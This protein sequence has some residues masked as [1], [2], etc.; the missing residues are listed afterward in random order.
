MRHGIGMDESDLPDS[1]ADQAGDRRLDV[2]AERIAMLFGQRRRKRALQEFAANVGDTLGDLV[3]LHRRVEKRLG[4]SGLFDY[5][6]AT[7]RG[8][9]RIAATKFGIGRGEASQAEFP[10]V[11]LKSTADLRRVGTELHL[12][13]RRARLTVPRTRPLARP[14]AVET[15]DGLLEPD[16]R[17]LE[18]HLPTRLEDIGRW[19]EEDSLIALPDVVLAAADTSWMAGGPTPMTRSG[20]WLR[21]YTQGG[22]AGQPDGDEVF[23]FQSALLSDDRIQSDERTVFFAGG[24]GIQNRYF[25]ALINTVP[26]LIWYR[27]L[28][29]SC[30]IVLPAL[31]CLLQPAL[32]AVIEC[33]FSALDI[34]IDRLLGAE[35]AGSRLFRLGILACSGDISD[36]TAH[37]YRSNVIPWF[38]DKAR[39]HATF[40]NHFLYVSRRAQPRRRIANEAE[41]AR[42]F[43]RYGFLIVEPER[44]S[45]FDQIE[46]FRGARV[47]AGVHGAGLVNMLFAEQGCLVIELVPQTPLRETFPSLASAC[48][49][50]YAPVM[51]D[52][53]SARIDREKVT[54]MLERLLARRRGHDIATR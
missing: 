9:G 15:F 48:G 8:A 51:S 12:T 7:Y 2:K 4:E 26:S 44:L 16:A 32:S 49:H 40:A 25:H 28:D 22:D 30:P 43:E 31:P 3:E 39:G 47:I 38:I 46:L 42:V 45:F 1:T 23:R 17:L 50:S 13:P 11:L 41:I 29:L 37:F 54:T 10:E 5:A 36:M 52:A 33:A 21:G 14:L 18:S 53:Y 6:Y 34:P 27:R 35:Q 24:G 20:E 19:R